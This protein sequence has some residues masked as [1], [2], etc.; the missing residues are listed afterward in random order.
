M[1]TSRLIEE[2]E[3]RNAEQDK[4]MLIAAQDIADQASPLTQQQ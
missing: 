4:T 1:D 2:I 3:K